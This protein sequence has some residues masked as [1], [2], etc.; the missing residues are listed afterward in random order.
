M[1]QAKFVMFIF[2]LAAMLSLFTIAYAI[3]LKTLLGVFGAII[4][5]CVVMMLGFKTKRKF[6]DKGML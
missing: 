1:K 5:L 3:A 6:K 4:L 2:A